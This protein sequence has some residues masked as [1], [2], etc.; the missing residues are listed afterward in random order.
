MTLFPYDS[1]IE[2]DVLHIIVIVRFA[3][4]YAYSQLSPAKA[5]IL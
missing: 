2:R 4:I 1:M 5:E 3:L